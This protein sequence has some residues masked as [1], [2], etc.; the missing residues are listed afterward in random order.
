MTFVDDRDLLRRVWNFL[1]ARQVPGLDR[2]A[3]QAADGVLTITGQL[4]TAQSRWLCV[5]CCRRVAGV[6]SVWDRVK[7]PRSAPFDPPINFPD[8]TVPARA[9][10]LAV[11]TPG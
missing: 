10:H 2:L 3:V 9:Y 4:P 1:Y 5:R 7:L 6:R 8:S 11:G